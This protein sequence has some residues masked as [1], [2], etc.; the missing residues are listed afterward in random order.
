MTGKILNVEDLDKLINMVTRLTNPL[1]LS[2]VMI[3]G[4]AVAREQYLKDLEIFDDLEEPC[5]HEPHTIKLE[6][7]FC[8][9][10]I[11]QKALKGWWANA[12]R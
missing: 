1:P 12:N 3:F 4:E 5:P 10:E 8:Y 9:T 6:C 7:R 11:K 2:E